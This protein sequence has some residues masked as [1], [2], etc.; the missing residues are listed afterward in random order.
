[1]TFTV[2]SEQVG[3]A[4]RAGVREYFSDVRNLVRMSPRFP[5]VRVHGGT[6]LVTPGTLRCRGLSFM[7]FYPAWWFQPFSP[8]C[9]GRL[10]PVRRGSTAGEFA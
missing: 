4:R 3:G 1:M 5:L 9:V 7:F 6:T 2:R 8:R 10:R